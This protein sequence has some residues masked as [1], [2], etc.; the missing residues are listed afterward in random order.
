MTA[1]RF[2]LV[3]A[4]LA[5][6]FGVLVSA[7]TL[8]AGRS[9]D[10]QGTVSRPTP[11]PEHYGQLRF[12]YVGGVGN[13]TIA[14][15]S[16]PGDINTY[17]VG[18]AS[19]GIFKTT[20][21]GAHWESIFD[22]QPV[23]SVGA[24]ALAPSDPNVVWAGTGESFIRSHISLGWGVFKS[25]DAGRTWTK[26]GLDD[27]GRI[28]RVIVHPTN[29]DI[30]Y[31]CASGHNFGPQPDRGVFRTTD[32]GRTWTKVLFVDENTGCSDL[33]MDPG[34]PRILFAGTWQIVIRTWGRESGGPGSGLWKSTDGGSTWK[35]LTGRG[36]PAKP[37]G[38][39]AVAIAQT[40]PDHVYA[41]IETGDGVPMKGE[42]QESG[43][44]WS[45]VDGGESWTLTSHDRQLAGRTHYYSRVVVST[46]NEH[47]AYFLSASFSKSIDGG[48]STVSLGQGASPGGDNHDMWID[49]TDPNRMAVANDPGVSISTNRGRSW[50][51]VQLPN[52]QFYH[53]TTDTRVPYYLYGNRQ[54]GPSYRGPSN[55]RSGGGG[56]GGGGGGAGSIGRGEWTNVC[57]GESGW[58]TPDPVN[59]DIIWSSASGRG[60][61]GGIVA[62]WDARNRQCRHVEIWPDNMTGSASADVKYRFVW[63][64]PLTISPHDHNKVYV[65]SQ[66]V[67][68]TTDGGNSWQIVSPDLTLNDKSKMGASGGLTLDS[69]GV[70]YAGVVFAIAESRLKPGLIWV[71]T[72]DGLVQVTQDGGKS[73]TNV[74]AAIPNLPPWLTIS[75]IEP[76]RFDAA[77]AYI[78]VDGHQ[79]NNRDAL[80]Y[81][82]TDLGKTWKSIVSGIPKSPLSYA[83]VIREDP[84]RRG[85]LYLGT[86]NA[87]YVSFDDGAN[88]QPMQGSMP[89]A[90]VYWIAVQEQFMD[91]VVATYGR[92]FYI[93]DDITPLQQLTPDVMARDA[94]LFDIRPAWR[95]RPVSAPM[96]MS[97]DPTA[98]VNPAY[99]ADINYYLKAASKGNVTIT[100][101]DQS[102]RTVR[103]LTGSKNPG[104]NRVQWDLRDEPTPQVMLRVSPLYAPYFDVPITGRPAPMAG[105]MTIQQP[106]G[107]YTVKLSVGGVD[108]TKQ[109]VV[110]KDPHSTGTEADIQKQVAALNDVKKAV[111]ELAGMLNRIEWI[112]RQLQ[113]IG[114]IVAASGGP[115]D[116]RSAAEALE[117]RFIALEGH[118]HQIKATG[119]GQEDI[120]WPTELMQ[121]LTYLAGGIA[122]ADFPPTTQALE[123]KRDFENRIRTYGAEYDQL[124]SGEL[125]AFNELL[126]KRN[127]ANVIVGR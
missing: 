87:L 115:A 64:A 114:H 90:P 111:T 71:G 78:A 61:V 99:G 86:E 97:D 31:V 8:Q 43:E 59:P 13:R 10:S 96:A 27:T 6:V 55:S 4:F 30:V 54:D 81:K 24:L 48:R 28:A 40:N 69:I 68:A 9:S 73:W 50:L 127:M 16:P 66:F 42:A 19:G 79:M 17:Y 41:L 83:H 63:T 77:T 126:R 70:E 62:I 107:T 46:D 2:V 45:S 15:V 125:G 26:M 118:L 117:Q 47:E 65:G 91:L 95:F 92:G 93:M 98:G 36:L 56:G 21:A 122:T 38:K 75:N 94:H 109:L 3:G 53:V 51:R 121:K 101:Q 80:V 102:G 52:A 11:A 119:R 113:D 35:R 120:R 25:T 60:S 123:V 84:V 76:S 39:V 100:I 12:R 34:N 58:A 116:V 14:V 32:G 33:A 108:D 67:H 82:T 23:S 104:I 44:L 57:G 72:N 37:V 106:P 5:L 124:L 89:N 105:R 20:D 74:T 112:R 110:R 85:L 1:K 103:T 49:P 22:D 18:S 88:W 7:P 29:P